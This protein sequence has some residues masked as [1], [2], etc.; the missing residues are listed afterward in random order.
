LIED[1]GYHARLLRQ[2]REF[3]ENPCLPPEPVPAGLVEDPLLMLAMDQFKD[4]RG[5]T[6]YAF[7]LPV[8]GLAAAAAWLAVI[9]E[10]LRRMKKLAGVRPAGIRID[11]CDAE[12]VR[13][14]MPSVGAA[15]QGHVGAV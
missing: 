7:R 5:F 12:I 1:G 2:V 6:S 15:S 3:R 8:G 14:W 10:P 13:R 11:C 4:L 9:V